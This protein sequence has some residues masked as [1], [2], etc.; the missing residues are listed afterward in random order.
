MKYLDDVFLIMGCA[1]LVF[2]VGLLSVP[3]AFI[4]SGLILIGAG[5][6]TSYL[7]S[8]NPAQEKRVES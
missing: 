8:V 7:R 6:Y 3:G 2:G 5:V 1:L 4:L